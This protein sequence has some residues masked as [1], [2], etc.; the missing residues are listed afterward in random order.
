M[1]FNKNLP[2]SGAQCQN[3][4]SG[5]LRINEL[6]I[7]LN[8]SYNPVIKLQKSGQ[9]TFPVR[10]KVLALLWKK[11]IYKQKYRENE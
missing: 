9:Q 8:A 5:I 3:L 1:K 10:Y 4:V 11:K 6:Y 2:N 7:L